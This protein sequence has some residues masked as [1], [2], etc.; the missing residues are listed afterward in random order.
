M[1]DGY[2]GGGYR[3]GFASDDQVAVQ[4][5]NALAKLRPQRLFKDLPVS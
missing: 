3:T 1:I 4:V 5:V 2:R